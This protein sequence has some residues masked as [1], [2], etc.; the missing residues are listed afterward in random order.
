MHVD[1]FWKNAVNTVKK[2]VQNVGPIIE[3]IDDF[4]ADVVDKIELYCA[5]SR[6][7]GPLS[8]PRHPSRQPTP[9]PHPISWCSPSHRPSGLR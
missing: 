5:V 8:P 7:H 3:A 2:S 4:V 6:A 9:L 1:K